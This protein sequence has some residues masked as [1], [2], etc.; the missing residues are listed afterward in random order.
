M[1]V[2]LVS[3][4]GRTLSRG[5]ELQGGSRGTSHQF[6]HNDLS[7]QRYLMT[8]CYW[9]LLGQRAH[10]SIVLDLGLRSAGPQGGNTTIL[11][12]EGDHLTAFTHRQHLQKQC[13]LTEWPTNTK[14]GILKK[15]TNTLQHSVH[16]KLI[17]EAEIPS[18]C[19]HRP[20][21]VV[22]AGWPYTRLSIS[23]QQA[24]LLLPL[25][26]QHLEAC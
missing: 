12:G 8:C 17:N 25:G 21:Q 6:L 10:L 18:V 5:S 24:C 2:V 14:E 15:K 16:P 26:F 19:I 23:G 20:E 13:F 11:K 3:W 4:T 9:P 7:A 22:P 1:S